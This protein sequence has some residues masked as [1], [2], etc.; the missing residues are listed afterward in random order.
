MTMRK[1]IVVGCLL[2]GIAIT[3][4][5]RFDTPQGRQPWLGRSSPRICNSSE[6]SW[7]CPK[8]SR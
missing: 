3:L 1:I 4:K 7:H 6:A 8:R 5:I 2:A